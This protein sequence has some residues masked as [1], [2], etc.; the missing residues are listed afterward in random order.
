VKVG[1]WNQGN[2]DP[3]ELEQEDSAALRLYFVEHHIAHIHNEREGEQ[4]TKGPGHRTP[5]VVGEKVNQK[6]E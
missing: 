6:R 1:G 3:L 2:T 4:G 5:K